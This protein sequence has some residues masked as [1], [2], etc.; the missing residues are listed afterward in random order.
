MSRGST[1]ACAANGHGWTM[2]KTRESLGALSYLAGRPQGTLRHLM[3]QVAHSRRRDFRHLL[4]ML[5]RN[6]W[7]LELKR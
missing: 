2:R 4:D 6:R 3:R 5:R 1:L 7:L